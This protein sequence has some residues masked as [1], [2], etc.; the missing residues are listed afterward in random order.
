MNT[1]NTGSRHGQQQRTNIGENETNRMSENQSQDFS[2]RE[3]LDLDF[4]KVEPCPQSSQHNYRMCIYFHNQMDRRRDPRRY[5][6]T[7]EFCQGMSVLGV[8]SLGDN[9]TYSHSKAEQAYHLEK[10]RRKFCSYYPENLQECPYQK[11]CSYAHS[12]EEIQTKL[13]HTLS[14]DIDFFIFHLKTHFCPVS[15]THDRAKCVYAH[16][17]QDFRRDLSQY[18]YSATLCRLW[19]RRDK[20]VDYESACPRGFQ[21]PEAHGISG[22]I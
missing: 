2:I 7:P 5:N 14:R 8:C 10:Y 12:E 20:V 6:Y 4:F 22:L 19:D 9:C 13:L 18:A 16:N 17:W 15:A 21:C 11:F 1:S 3:Q